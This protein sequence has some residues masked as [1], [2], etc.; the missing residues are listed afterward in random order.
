M[1]PEQLAAGAFAVMEVISI[2]SSG[3][4]RE[5]L[6]AGESNRAGKRFAVN[7]VV[8]SAEKKVARDT[9]LLASRARS[10]RPHSARLLLRGIYFQ[11][12]NSLICA[13]DWRGSEIIESHSLHTPT[14]MFEKVTAERFMRMSRVS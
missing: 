7:E 5:W 13:I 11:Q 8:R 14:R 2:S 10:G 12:L 6:T 3:A 1:P 9:D 4:E